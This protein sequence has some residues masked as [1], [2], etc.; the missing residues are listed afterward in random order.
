MGVRF[1]APKL[2]YAITDADTALS[3][4]I[5]PLVPMTIDALERR[6][7]PAFWYDRQSF[8]LAYNDISRQQW[9]LLMDAKEDIIREIRGVR[10][11]FGGA[12]TTLEAFPVGTYPGVQL[13][14][15][16]VSLYSDESV[17]VANLL[18]EIRNILQTQGQGDEGQLDALL[19]IVALLSV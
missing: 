18:T 16:V 8:E 7:S 6:K 17:N 9:N 3:V 2:L 15:V 1:F 13:R 14:D 11:S 19:Q 12:D 5:T 4:I 10:G